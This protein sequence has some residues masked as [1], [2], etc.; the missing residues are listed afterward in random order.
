M[1]ARPNYIPPE[2][3][4]QVL[5]AIPSLH[6]R[7]WKDE[8]IQM[9]FRMA[10]W[11]ELR[12]GEAIRLQAEDFDL[13]MNKVY[14][15]KTKANKNDDTGI[16]PLFRMELSLYLQGKTGPLFPGLTY[17]TAVKWLERLGKTLNILAWTVKQSETGEKTKTHIFRKS[18]A[19][20]LLYGTF[21]K[22]APVNV[23]SQSLR[24][25]GKN[26]LATTFHYLKVSSDDVNNWWEDNTKND[27]D[28]VSV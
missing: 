13:I 4:E 10:Y 28:L 8:D 16:P 19:K 23:I 14:L 12:F 18:M 9:L 15:G 17:G 24:H 7:K 2:Q 1:R 25:K 27:S 26:P 22:K 6:I 5:E 20:D 21:G 3:F 11:L